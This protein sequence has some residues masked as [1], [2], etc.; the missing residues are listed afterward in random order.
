MVSFLSNL[1]RLLRE[2]VFVT[3]SIGLIGIKFQ[4]ITLVRSAI[5]DDKKTQDKLGIA[6]NIYL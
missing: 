3:S 2:T 1:L 6:S 5:Q 4:E